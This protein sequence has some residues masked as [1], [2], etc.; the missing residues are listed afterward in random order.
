MASDD[1]DL[2]ALLAET[3][4][5]KDACRNLG[6]DEESAFFIKHSKALQRKYKPGRKQAARA[7]EASSKLH[8][9]PPSSAGFSWC[10]DP[11]TDGFPGFGAKGIKMKNWEA[12]VAHLNEQKAG[13]GEDWQPDWRGSRG[14]TAS[15]AAHG[16]GVCNVRKYQSMVTGEDDVVYARVVELDKGKTYLFEKG[17]ITKEAEHDWYVQQGLFLKGK[18]GSSSS[19][20]APQVQVAPD[21][22]DDAEEEAAEEQASAPQRKQRRTA[23]RS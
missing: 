11:K 16:K 5:L 19:S 4:K 15:M 23:K 14:S 13:G 17:E 12:C 8:A 20:A 9:D 10:S 21:P 7:G 6:M 1:I 2:D 22:P 3:E 18:K